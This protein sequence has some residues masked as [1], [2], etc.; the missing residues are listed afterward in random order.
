MT[1]TREQLEQTHTDLLCNIIT[2][3]CDSGV[4]EYLQ[5]ARMCKEILRG[6]GWNVRYRREPCPY[7][8]D[9]TRRIASLI[10]LKEKSNE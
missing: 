5:E 3:V 6:R 7:G 1:F 10:P 9:H 2:S 4:P 8:H